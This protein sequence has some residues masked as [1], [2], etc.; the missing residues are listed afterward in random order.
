MVS[1]DALFNNR[2]AHITTLAAR[3]AVPAIY[4]WREAVQVGGLMSYGSI[5]L[6][7][8]RQPGIWVALGGRANGRDWRTSAANPSRERPP[9]SAAATASP[10]E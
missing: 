2:L 1:P 9:G 7:L 10:A 5:A 6:D 8:F 3:H 4:P